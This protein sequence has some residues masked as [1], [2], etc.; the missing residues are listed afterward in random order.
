M[1]PFDTKT[2]EIP[3]NGT[4]SQTVHSDDHVKVVVFAFDA[5]QELS[6]HRAASA[7]TVVVTR[8]TLRFR[9]DGDEFPLAPG[10]FVHMPA[11]APHALRAEEPTVM[12]LT[13]LR[14]DRG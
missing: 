2:V 4:L 1:P 6:E 9:L 11:G 13:L 10:G 14:D 12:L 7:A 3:V 8:G 5:G